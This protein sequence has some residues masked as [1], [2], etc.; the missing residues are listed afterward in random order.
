MTP[1]EALQNQLAANQAAIESKDA[2]IRKLLDERDTLQLEIIH[3]KKAEFKV[4]PYSVACES[5]VTKLQSTVFKHSNEIDALKL[6]VDGL[7]D[8]H[9]ETVDNFKMFLAMGNPSA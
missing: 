3:L 6:I 1:L 4:K 9:N 2:A 7:L 5:E 8:A